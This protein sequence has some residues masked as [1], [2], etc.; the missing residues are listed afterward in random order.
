MSRLVLRKIKGN[1]KIQCAVCSFAVLTKCM[2]DLSFLLLRASRELLNLMRLRKKPPLVS[3]ALVDYEGQKVSDLIREKLTSSS[4]CMIARLGDTELTCIIEYCNS[5]LGSERYVKYVLGEIDS[6]KIS[7]AY[8]HAA[9]NNAGIFPSTVETL[10][11]FAKLMLQDMEEVD[12]LGSWR[13]QESYFKKELS[14]ATKV[15]LSDLEP[16]YHKDPWTSCLKGKDVLIVHPFVDT[17]KAQYKKRT[18]LFENE[19]ILPEF[20]L[21]TIRAVQSIAAEK[22]DFKDWFEALDY[23]KS[24]I[25]KT[26]FDIAIIG[27]GGY[28]FPLA[29]HVK[30]MGKKAV[31]LGGATQLLFGIKGYRWSNHDVISRLF[32]EHWVHP[33]KEE[34][35]QSYKKMEG[36]AHW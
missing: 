30:R 7:Q 6:Y 32:N 18:K 23:M 19:L 13:R 33:I 2:E 5:Q 10:S 14:K 3:Y 34:T 9:K 29:A 1:T 17:I 31:H 22:V 21:K 15:K 28:G 20:N 27:C 8:L 24:A 11:K 16:Y 12:I 26:S 35:P 4:P 36:G 25:D